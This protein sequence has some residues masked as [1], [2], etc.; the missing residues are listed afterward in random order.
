MRGSDPWSL[1][2]VRKSRTFMAMRLVFFEAP[3]FTRLLSTYLTDDQYRTVQQALLEDPERGAVMP[4]YGWFPQIAL[5]GSATRE[6]QAW[7]SADHLL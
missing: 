5:G 6:R 2:N 7:W 1:I 3:I 4:G